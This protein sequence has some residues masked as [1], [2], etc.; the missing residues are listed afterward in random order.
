M[1]GISTNVYTQ[2]ECAFLWH[3]HRAT[4]TTDTSLLLHPQQQ[5]LYGS[6]TV[7]D[8]PEV[9]LCSSPLHTQQ[10][11]FSPPTL[12]ITTTY[13]RTGRHRHIILRHD[14]QIYL[15]K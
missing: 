13:E 4:H 5:L 11:L 3:F 7:Q 2:G 6:S 10:E 14:S 15:F 12:V 1:A 8:T 9:F